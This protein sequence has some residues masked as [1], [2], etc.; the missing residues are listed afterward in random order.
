M[1]QKYSEGLRSSIVARYFNGESVAI[2]SA[3]ASIPRSTLYHWIKQSRKLKSSSGAEIAYQDYSNLKRRADRLEEKLRVIKAAECSLSAPLQEKLTALEKLCG[4]FSVR[5][6][7]EALEVARGT[8][9]NHIFRRKVITQYDIRRE[10]I[11]EQVKFVFDES[12]QRFGAKKICAVLAARNIKTS[13]RYVS[14]LM[15]EMDLQ[16]V[17]RN[18][19]REYKKQAGRTRRQNILQQQFIVTAPNRVWV[20]DTT[21]FRVKEVNYYVCVIID[22]FSRKVVAH[23]ISKRHSTY[24]VTTT[25]KRAFQSRGH[26]SQLTFHSD[27]GAQYTSKTFQNLLRVNNHCPIV[28]SIQET[29]RQCSSRSIFLRPKERR[30][31]SHKL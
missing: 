25:V 23:N 4:Q 2:L 19:K 10:E 3:N 24:L 15:K 17:G 31:L 1:N 6:L 29:P 9:Y 22:L 28:L 13:P 26:P 27:Q 8:F 5:V 11:R 7:C 12:K 30:T 18:S 16:S 21:H 14:D 20:S